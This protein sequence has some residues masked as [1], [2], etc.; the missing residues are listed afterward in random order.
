MTFALEI[1]IGLV[2]GLV[3]GAL[4]G[5]GGVLTVPALIYLLG[6]ST[7]EAAT[8]SLIIVGVAALAGLPAHAWRGNVRWGAGVV[9]GLVGTVAALAGAVGARYLDPSVLLLAFA[10]VITV[11]AALMIRDAR[12]GQAG[13]EPTDECAVDVVP[14]GGGDVT[15]RP[16]NP[17]TSPSPLPDGGALLTVPRPST[18]PATGDRSRT[19]QALM[20]VGGGLAVG[21]MTGLF[22][23]GGGFLAVPVLVLVMRWPT[24][25]AIGTSL[26]VI[27]INAVAALAPRLGAEV[28]DVRLIIPVTV[29]AVVGTLLGKVASDRV[30]SPAL[31][32][33]F[34]AV[35]LLLAGYTALRSGIA[36]TA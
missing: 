12:R 5:G 21:L 3:V 34:A 17:S 14:A 6:A 28:L 22:G 9:F 25:A 23:V 1:A 30:S 18:E 35:L 13:E 33:I 26:L 29:A 2:I 27:V 8:A 32:R 19:A 16:S 31:C 10:G 7:H 24:R 20:V 36:L 11:A 4:G 15:E